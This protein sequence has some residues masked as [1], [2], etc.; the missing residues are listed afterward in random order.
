MAKSKKQPKGEN[1]KVL[2]EKVEKVSTETKEL[3]LSTQC[4]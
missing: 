4:K 1:R 3:K 2:P